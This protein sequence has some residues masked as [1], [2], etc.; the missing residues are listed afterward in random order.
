MK[1]A[2]TLIA[3]L[4]LLMSM[5]LIAAPLTSA[6][7]TG[8]WIDRKGA[9]L[10][11]PYEEAKD[12]TYEPIPGS[13]SSSGS[14]G[15]AGATFSLP[16]GKEAFKVSFD[17]DWVTPRRFDDSNESTAQKNFFIWINYGYTSKD[18]MESWVGFDESKAPWET[19]SEANFTLWNNK[20]GVAY[21]AYT[22]GRELAFPADA[23]E[24]ADETVTNLI[25][26]KTKQPITDKI[27]WITPDA[28]MN[29]A[30]AGTVHITLELKNDVVSLN[31]KKKADG[32]DLGT[33]KAYYKDGY[34]NSKTERYFAI[35]HFNGA[36]VWDITNFKIE[37]SDIAS[38]VGATPG[39]REYDENGQPIGDTGAT[40]PPET[41]TNTT[42]AGSNDNKTTGA[43]AN[44]NTTTANTADGTTAPAGSAD[45]DTT[46]TAP[47][48]EP[49]SGND[50]PT[51]GGADN[52]NDTS[53][54][55]DGD[56][57]TDPDGD[58]AGF[59]VW[60][61]IVIAV[62]VLAGAGVA[63]FFVLKKK[64]A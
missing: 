37:S 41:P 9:D 15:I 53:A 54:P 2:L 36:F 60:A 63:V 62:V 19:A 14:F 45:A 61:I 6:A 22:D 57:P 4:S 27:E 31:V 58:S 1:R 59:P 20:V 10:T 49:D 8:E 47:D 35:T 21:P 30:K 25:S 12:S 5:L 17:L 44:N 26:F 33:A 24:N 51:D 23:G 18:E 55:V 13:L 40:K 28:G 16:I 38:S 46:T 39:G 52:N 34:F 7:A 48:G 56:D 43:A 42:A 32:T 29:I 3:V 11:E 64:K 50:A